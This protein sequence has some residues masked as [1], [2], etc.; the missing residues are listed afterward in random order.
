[1]KAFLKHGSPAPDK[2]STVPRRTPSQEGD[3][4]SMP[5]LGSEESPRDSSK[6]A[7]ET[8][9]FQPNTAEKTAVNALLMAA[10]A[11]TEMSGHSAPL[12][13]FQPLV[14]TPPDPRT[15]M[16]PEQDEEFQ[17]EECKT[18]Q[19]NLLRQFQSPK[20]KQAEASPHQQ[21]TPKACGKLRSEYNGES[22]TESSP[23]GTG[24]DS[25]EDSPKRD[26]T[27]ITDL[28]P[29]VQQKIK[30]SRI[31]S[32]RKGPSRNLGQ[33][34]VLGHPSPMQMETPKHAKAPASNDLTPVSAR[35]IDFKR[36]HVGKGTP[37]PK[38]NSPSATKETGFDATKPLS[39]VS[40]NAQ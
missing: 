32:V 34:L 24:E 11:M 18:P 3:V 10:F 35:C 37:E 19:K 29:S 12:E 27:D 31:G 5:S 17:E 9:T 38:A 20:R 7:D 33:E 39:L 2:S 8:F 1:M 16:I 4:G 15:T 36:M 22:S 26:L 14:S 13:S 6:G 23:S 25:S 21:E 40:R 28:T 30:R